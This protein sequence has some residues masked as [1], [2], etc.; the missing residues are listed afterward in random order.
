MPLLKDSPFQRGEDKAFQSERWISSRQSLQLG[1]E[2]SV[3]DY[4]ELAIWIEG[5]RPSF[6]FER[7]GVGGRKLVAR[8]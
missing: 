5:S 1:K 4:C 8:V 6:I 3:L 2:Q 7:V